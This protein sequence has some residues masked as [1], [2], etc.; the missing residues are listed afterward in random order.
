MS[1]NRLIVFPFRLRVQA[2]I[3]SLGMLDGRRAAVTGQMEEP[4]VAVVG[5]PGRKDRSG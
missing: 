3:T 2:A 4:V 1:G 5:E